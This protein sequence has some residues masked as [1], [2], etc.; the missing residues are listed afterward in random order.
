MK[1]KKKCLNHV[2]SII[3][4]NKYVLGFLDGCFLVVLRAQ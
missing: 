1:K 3:S 2:L 4:V